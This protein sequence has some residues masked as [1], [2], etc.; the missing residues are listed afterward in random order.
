MDTAPKMFSSSPPV[1]AALD[2]SRFSLK[3]VS[4]VRAYETRN[5]VLVRQQVGEPQTGLHSVRGRHA[6]VLIVA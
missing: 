4:K 5:T 2:R 3:G 6:V 1:P